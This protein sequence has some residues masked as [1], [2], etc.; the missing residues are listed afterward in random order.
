MYIKPTKSV[1]FMALAA[2]LAGS[3]VAEYEAD[4][5][6]AAKRKRNVLYYELGYNPCFWPKGKP[7]SVAAF[8]SVNS[9]NES[10]DA[11]ARTPVNIDTFIYVPIGGFATLSAK[12]PSVDNP[13]AQPN[14]NTRYLSG[15]VNML[16]EFY[17]AGTDPLAE[18]CKWARENKKEMICCLPINNLSHDNGDEKGGVGMWNNYFASP[19]KKKN[20]TSLMGDKSGSTKAAAEYAKRETPPFCHRWAVDYGKTEVR[21]KFVQVCTEIVN[22]YD[23]DGLMIDFTFEPYIFR[24]V[25]WGETASAKDLADL[26]AMVTSIRAACKAAS[27]KKGHAVMLTIRVPDSV[28]YCKDIGIDLNAWAA[29]K[30]FDFIVAGGDF[31]LNPPSVMGEFAKTAGVPYYQSCGVSYIFTGN[32][33]GYP[34]DDERPGLT[35]QGPHCFRGRAMAAYKGGASGIMYWNPTRWH[36]FSMRSLAPDP[37]TMKYENKR[38]CVTYQSMGAMTRAVKDGRKHCTLPLLFSG[39]PVDLGKGAVKY[40]INVWDDLP[41]LKKEGK[42]V[43]IVRLTTEVSLPSGTDIVAQLNGKPLKLRKKRAGSQVFDVPY[44]LAKYGANEAVVKATGKNKRG[45]TPKLGN[46]AIDVI[47]DENDGEVAK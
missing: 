2:L 31:E 18:V 8:R 9:A 12:I 44:D 27:A 1:A 25:A 35:R 34:D 29:A 40:P 42:K 14:K 10:L 37:A 33:S 17:K 24:S 15:Q 30:L 26:T 20:G 46:I 45:Q 19:W 4:C 28:G 38:Y 5:K 47:F 32:D 22:K 21:T 36:R 39:S 43:P 23:I 11:Y 13:T 3:A 6:A 16:S 7:F 41:A